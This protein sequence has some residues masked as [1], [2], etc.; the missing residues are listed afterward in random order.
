MS[1]CDSGSSTW[2]LKPLN[3]DLIGT[4]NV[5]ITWSSAEEKQDG[6]GLKY[7]QRKEVILRKMFLKFSKSFLFSYKYD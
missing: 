3:A 6:R 7:F 1:Q 4:N 2:A 5:N